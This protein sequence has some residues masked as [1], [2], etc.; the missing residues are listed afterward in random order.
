VCFNTAEGWSR[1]VSED[2]AD[3]IRRRCHWEARE[4][5]EVSYAF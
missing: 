3:A 4:P 5:P 2:I 1:D